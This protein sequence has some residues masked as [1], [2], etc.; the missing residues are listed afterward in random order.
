MKLLAKNPVNRY[1]SAEELVADLKRYREGRHPPSWPRAAAGAA[2]PPSPAPPRCAATRPRSCHHRRSA[3]TPARRTGS[4]ARRDRSTPHRLR[5]AAPPPG[6]VGGAAIIRLLALLAV[7]GWLLQP[8]TRR[9]PA[10][11]PVDVPDVVG[12]PQAEAERILTEPASCRRGGRRSADFAAGIVDQPGPRAR[13]RSTRSQRARW[14][15]LGHHPGRAAQPGGLTEQEAD[16][17]LALARPRAR[18]DPAGDRP[19]AE[20]TVLDQDPPGQVARAAPCRWSCRSGRARW[21]CPTW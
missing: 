8:G 14:R 16:A 1:S 10:R 17:A 5:R 15:Q 21:R 6:L 12:Q 9:R 18:G 11:S 20:G 19:T 13:H 2:G 7:G 3:A 4:P